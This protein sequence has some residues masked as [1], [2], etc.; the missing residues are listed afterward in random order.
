M[1]DDQT[2]QRRQDE[3]IER[4][5]RVQEVASNLRQGNVPSND[6]LVQGI[7]KLR[8]SEVV[9]N[10][11]KNM[12]P[13]GQQV[14]Q[15]L[16]QVLDTSKQVIQEKNSDQEL[17]TIVQDGIHGS[18]GA[19]DIG[20]QHVSDQHIR[21]GQASA[22]ELAQEAGRRAWNVTRLMVTSREFRRLVADLEGI[23]SDSIRASITGDEEMKQNVGS[24]IGSNTE[25]APQDAFQRTG[26][27]ARGHAGDVYRAGVE[28]TQP[29]VDKYARGESTFT[30]AGQEI[31]SNVTSGIK[32]SVSGINLSPE[33][34]NTLLQRLKNVLLEVH[35]SQEYQTAVD[36]LIYIIRQIGEQ[37][38]QFG[39]QLKQAH[40][41]TQ[42]AHGDHIDNVTQSSKQ[43]VEKFANG[44]SLDP[45]INA[46]REFGSHVK[47]DQ[48]MRNYLTD[49]R[50][51][52]HKSIRDTSFIQSEE[53]DQKASDLLDRGQNEMKERYQGDTDRLIDEAKTFGQGFKE[54]TLNQ[55]LAD[56]LQNLTK[57]VFLDEEGKPTFKYELFKDFASMIPV[58][59]AQI[60]YLPLPPIEGSDAEIDYKINNLVLRCSNVIPRY[61]KI[62]TDT[63]VHMEPPSEHSDRVQSTGKGTADISNQVTIQLSHV[64]AD[65][66]D[67]QFEF[68]KKTGIKVADSGLADIHIPDRGL[69]V[70]MVVKNSTP[71]ANSN[72]M[73][74]VKVQCKLHE[75]KLKMRDTKH[76][77]MYKLLSPIINTA[78]KKNAEKA[79]AEELK[80]VLIRMDQRAGE[81]QAKA[82]AQDAHQTVK[83]NIQS[84]ADSFNAADRNRETAK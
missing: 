75:L 8:T 15:N 47:D 26:D 48:E 64:R 79:I 83:S 68:R 54:D 35:S 37:G 51:F 6:N 56:D 14:M 13:A 36:D 31:G 63:E 76:D 22:Q 19:A 50:E 34:R 23:V 72:V 60:E 1:S 39:G 38:E 70:T 84:N 55:K 41:S 42:E 62:H 7:D 30:E 78:F 77:T 65:A 74:V 12:S 3:A 81:L 53:Y 44:N 52:I 24:N 33:Q 27:T 66:R 57:S 46:V 61:V 71:N 5:E 25:A 11:S 21:E 49:L 9:D 4:K 18:K 59:A 17:Q 43:L 40:E 82:T 2:R 16:N 45:L 67:V 29:T 32:K 58:I 80:K 10:T 73:E 28:N 20:K 69:D